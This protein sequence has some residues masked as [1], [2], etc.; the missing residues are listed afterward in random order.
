VHRHEEHTQGWGAHVPRDMM[1]DKR[2]GPFG[3]T[4]SVKGHKTPKGHDDS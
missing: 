1:V 3:R 2:M 4:G